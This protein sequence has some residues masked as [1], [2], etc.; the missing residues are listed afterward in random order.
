MKRK[1]ILTILFALMFILIIN[2][3][4]SF[5]VSIAELATQGQAAVGQTIDIR[6]SDL[7]NN[8]NL[9]CILQGQENSGNT[10]YKVLTHIHI[11]DGI[12]TVKQVTEGS[13]HV[14]GE[15]R[16]NKI[17]AE[18][19]SGN[20]G[21]G[22][23]S[24]YHN[25]TDAQKAV[26]YYLTTWISEVGESVLINHSWDANNNYADDGTA[27]SVITRATAAV[28]AG[29]N[30]AVDLY[31]LDDWEGKAGWQRLMIVN[32]S[33]TSNGQVVIKK[34]SSE[35]G[36]RMGNVGLTIKNLST[37]EYISSVE[38][39]DANSNIMKVIGYTTDSSSAFQFKTK[40]NKDIILQ[41]LSSGKYQ[42]TEISNPNKGYEENKGTTKTFL[43][44]SNN[45]ATITIYNSKDDT[46]EPE[47][48]P[49]PGNGNVSISGTVWEYEASGKNS[50][51][52]SKKGSVSG[53]KVY[54]K[55]SS[56]N[57]IA[58]T[59]TDSNGNYTMKASI[60]IKNHTYSINES[61]YNK[62]NN[63]YVEF[64]YNGLKYTTISPSTSLGSNK[65]IGTEIKSTRDVLDAKFKEIEGNGNTSQIR[66]SGNTIT[67]NRSGNASNVNEVNQNY[68][69][70]FLVR[71]NSK[72]TGV[73]NL[74]KS[75]ASIGTGRYCVKESTYMHYCERRHPNGQKRT[76]HEYDDKPNSWTVTNMN[77]GLVTR[78]Q[79]DIA[80]KTDIS[81]VRVIMKGQ[82]YTYNYG[83]R[84]IA[85]I[86]APNVQF[87]N[88]GKVYSRPINPSDIQ[89]I[90]ENNSNDLEVYVTY[91]TIVYNQSN[92]LK[93]TV[94]EIANY[95]DQNYELV[96]SGWSTSSKYGH[97]YNNGGYKAIYNTSLSG[98]VLEPGAKSQTV[99]VEFKVK[100]STLQEI[101]NKNNKTLREHTDLFDVA[102]VSTYSTYY[103]SSTMCAEQKNAS[104]AGLVGQSYAGI[105]KDSAPLNATPGNEGTYE[106][107]TDKAPVFQITIDDEKIVSGT[108]WED[109]Q[110]S[111]S[112][113]NNERLGNGTKDNGENGVGNVKVELLKA[114]TNE[115]ALL[116]PRGQS[117]VPAVTTTAAD[118][119]YN[120][121]GVVVDNYIIRYTYGGDIDYNNTKITSTINGNEIDARNYKSTIITTDPVKSVINGSSDSIKWHLTEQDNASVAVDD[122]SNA[123]GGRANI[124]NKDLIYSNFAEKQ[125]VSS[126][127]KPFKIQVEYTENQEQGV[128]ENGQPTG[129]DNFTYNWPV[130][131][132]G[133]IERP[134]EDMVID[135]TISNL[136]ITL[137]NGQ[138]LTEGDPRKDTLSYVKSTNIK[139]GALTNTLLNTREAVKKSNEKLLSIEMDSE[140]IQGSTIDITYAITVTNNNEKDYVYSTNQT[141]YYYY[142]NKNSLDLIRESANLV[143]DYMDSDLTCVAGSNTENSDWTQ[144]QADTLK[145]TGYIS[146]ETFN[147]VQPSAS[148]YL[149]FITDKFK[150]LASGESTTS[151]IH[152]SKLLANKASDYTFENHVEIIRLDG[153]TA[154][155]IDST[156]STGKQVAK[157]Y[158]PGTYIPSLNRV[159]ATYTALTDTRNRGRLWTDASKVKND[160]GA[161]IHTQDD[162]MIR[163]TITPPTGST[164]N[165]MTYIIAGLVSLSIVAVGIYIIKKKIVL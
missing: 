100:T 98:T 61:E 4:K 140:L 137:A 91:D 10:T 83:H 133:I 88:D 46:D 94:P 126:Y 49:G 130:F 25:Y 31:L 41:G 160:S 135:K 5:G 65:S 71:A 78:E 113:A 59:T 147:T 54:W 7:L 11:E 36:A 37:G 23:G 22:Y 57:N 152:A 138:V 119:S 145:N 81:K 40:S 13:A 42:I 45:G 70:N 29:A 125:Y 86:S 2:I 43:L 149:I 121:T 132:F 90:A 15:S 64:E 18:I 55:D 116:Y 158:K 19:V 3:P 9:Y 163:I 53:I 123:N 108:V 76:S 82:E 12:A 21:L 33:T 141:G 159:T 104:S 69:S 58:S 1:S 50:S 122:L 35:S 63:S 14:S 80:L 155:T 164:N 150:D 20:Y 26:Y 148:N 60:S 27:A 105:D 151:Y 157:T 136:K 124:D 101:F 114:D 17:L 93:M 51:S 106:D 146:E 97:T 109:T 144:V 134:R 153:K 128:K 111:E 165:V 8:P 74:L 87:S 156:E 75:H 52:I 112:K 39:I 28:D 99:S 110:T 16:A 67:Y 107:D 30:P 131:D 103:G 143:V 95:Y 38:L 115:V 6:A 24:A 48:E 34:I 85:N 129:A 162:D 89:Y 73:N 96:S 79:P 56:G 77:L 92:T 84:G 72:I 161:T 62:Y 127:T 102:E 117:P 68:N 47:P 120:F 142:G 44:E 118:G 154:R 32:P 139:N 66:D